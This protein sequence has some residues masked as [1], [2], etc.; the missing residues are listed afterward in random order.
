MSD[1]NDDQDL[2]RF[3]AYLRCLAEV[4]LGPAFQSKLDPSDVVQETFLEA[5]QSLEQFRGH[6]DGELAAWLRQI[7]QTRLGN[8]LRDLRRDKRDLRREYSLEQA[9]DNSSAK[10]VAVL[11]AADPSPSKNAEHREDFLRVADALESLPDDQRQVILLKHWCSHS[12]SE[13]QAQ[14]GRTKHAVV[15]LLRRGLKTLREKLKVQD[16]TCPQA[17]PSPKA[18]P[19]GKSA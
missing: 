11:H 14:T 5:Y 7:L 12:L 18:P 2:N 19:S 4:G 10:L 1:V 13:I 8:T 3:R 9:L 15:G 6:T 17:R 16:D